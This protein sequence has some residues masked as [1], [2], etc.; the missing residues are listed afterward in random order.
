[1]GYRSSDQ[2]FGTEQ[3]Q[4]QIW[5][6]RRQ[7]FQQ[8]RKGIREVYATGFRNPH[9]ISWSKAGQMFVGNIGQRNIESLY[10]VEPGHFYGWPIREGTFLILDN[11]DKVY[12]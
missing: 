8:E 9:K 12:P 11:I 5:Y 3:R 1:M 2:S 7:S 6:S 10:L 4:W